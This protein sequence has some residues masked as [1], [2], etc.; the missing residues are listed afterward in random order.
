MVFFLDLDRTIFDFESFKKEVLVPNSDFKPYIDESDKFD[1]RS[2]ERQAVWNRFGAFLASLPEPF[3]HTRFE[4]YAFPDALD[5]LE[6]HGSDIVIITLGNPYFQRLK[7]ERTLSGL[8]WRDTLYVESG[9]KGP[10]VRDFLK[11][12]E[13]AVFVDDAVEELA[14]V[15]QECPWI[16]AYEMRRDGKEGNGAFPVIHT[17]DE[18]EA[19]L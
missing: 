18:L 10:V 9:L 13:P 4:R 6:R 19:T 3:A 7:V 15:R 17:F 5:F 14:S 2:P 12:E 8:E 1:R 16:P 11:T